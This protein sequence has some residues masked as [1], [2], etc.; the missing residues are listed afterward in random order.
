MV[1]FC[2]FMCLSCQRHEEACLT[3]LC[4]TRVNVGC[5][6]VEQ[7]LR[8]AE[9]QLH[10]IHMLVPKEIQL[11]QLYPHYSSGAVSVC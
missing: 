4:D 7:T 2:D 6:W 5:S 11:Q 3:R 10:R 1:V 8:G 9:V